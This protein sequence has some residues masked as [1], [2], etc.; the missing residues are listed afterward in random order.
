[1]T[2][3]VTAVSIMGAHSKLGR[4]FAILRGGRDL[5]IDDNDGAV[6]WGAKGDIDLRLRWQSN[7]ELVIDYPKNARI[8][9]QKNK[10]G[11]VAIFYAAM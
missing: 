11:D 7:T 8:I 3:Y 9:R 10:D 1:M 5:L 6:R 2:G 4:E